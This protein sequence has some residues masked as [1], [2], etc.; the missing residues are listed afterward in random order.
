M[1]SRVFTGGRSSLRLVTRASQSNPFDFIG[2]KAPFSTEEGAAENKPADPPTQEEI[3][4]G[5]QEWGIKYDD[6][7][8]KFEKE[9]KELVVTMIDLSEFIKVKKFLWG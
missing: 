1:L 3:E 2:R 6:E 8:L 9:W 4:K 7:C 5:R